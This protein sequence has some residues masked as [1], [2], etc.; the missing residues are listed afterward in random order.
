[1]LAHTFPAV[2]RVISVLQSSEFNGPV[3]FSQLL[4]YQTVEELW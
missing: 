4:F 3:E 2:N 1:M